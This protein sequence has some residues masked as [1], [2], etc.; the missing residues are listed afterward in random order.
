MDVA[1]RIFFI[2]S[3]GLNLKIF[4]EIKKIS[5]GTIFVGASLILSLC[6]PELC[7]A[8]PDTCVDLGREIQN[9][10]AVEC[11]NDADKG[12]REEP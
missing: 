3:F 11:T 1:R 6:V 10:S 2:V 8:G 12:L 4:K 7:D 9:Q 5:K